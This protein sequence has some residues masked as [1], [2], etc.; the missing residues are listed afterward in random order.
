M[1]DFTDLQLVSAAQEGNQRALNI[2]VTR[3]RAAIERQVQRFALGHAE[4]E[5]ILQDVIVQLL[6]K[7]QTFRGDSQFSTWL[8][9]VT[10]NT[11]LM[12]LR[13]ARRRSITSLDACE[14]EAEKM[15][16]AAQDHSTIAWSAPA[17][18]Q[19]DVSSQRSTVQTAVRDLPDGYQDVIIGHYFDGLALVQLADQLGTSESAVRSRLHRARTSLRRSLQGP[20]SDADVSEAP[21]SSAA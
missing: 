6:R 12:Y 5:D 13:K 8:Y 14:H 16:A 1:N 4:R 21:I 18:E 9:R 20:V 15:L 2:L 10:A 11:A 19:L 7:I 3:H 17:D